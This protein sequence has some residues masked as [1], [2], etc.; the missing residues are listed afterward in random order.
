MCYLH[1]LFHIDI[2]VPVLDFPTCDLENTE[3]ILTLVG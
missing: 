2:C 3:F 1:V